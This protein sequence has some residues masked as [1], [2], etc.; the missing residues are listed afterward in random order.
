MA[1]YTIHQTKRNLFIVEL[2]A[3]LDKNGNL[4]EGYNPTFASWENGIKFESASTNAA[5]IANEF[6]SQKR[7]A[8][9]VIRESFEANLNEFWKDV[10]SRVG[11]DVCTPFINKFPNDSFVAYDNGTVW[12]KTQRTIYRLRNCTAGRTSYPNAVKQVVSFGSLF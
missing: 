9:A 6:L 8:N 7:A 4:K 11:M 12:S 10:D 1:T 2:S 3:Q 5:T